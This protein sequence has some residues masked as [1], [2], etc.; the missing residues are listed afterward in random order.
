[1]KCPHCQSFIAKI[2]V[3][4]KC[5]YCS[6]KLPEPGK[7]YLF[8]EHL[9]EYLDDK[10]I[11]FWSI[12]F[13]IGLIA[14]AIP[15]MAWGRAHLFS[16]IGNSLIMTIVFIFYG[17][18]LIDMCVRINLPIRM[19]YGT[20]FILKERVVIRNV[21][22]ITNLFTIVGIGFSFYWLGPVV[23]FNYFPSYLV[24][25]SGF[26]AFGWAIAGLFI[27]RRMVEDVRFRF[28]MDRLGISSLKRLRRYSSL[29]IGILVLSAAG[30]Y[31][32][33]GISGIWLKFSNLPM[34]GVIIYFTKE[35][36]AWLF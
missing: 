32:L 9:I 22:K 19:P 13:A 21:R 20:D 12:W 7:L 3:S 27:D 5:P 24:V 16:Y 34:V 6:E 30:F 4:W 10:G 33:M 1:M 14:I 25:M 18:M 17:G 15:E 36:F 8:K 2:P 31:I 35:Y 26:I 23:L 11:L 28:Y 29:T